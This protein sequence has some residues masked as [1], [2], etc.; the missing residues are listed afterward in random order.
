MAIEEITPQQARARQQLGAVLIDVREDDEHALGAPADALLRPRASL[1][2]DPAQSIP[3]LSVEVVLICGSGKRSMLAARALEN[4][5]Y[6]HVASIA[7][8]F[9]AWQAAGLPISSRHDA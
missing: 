8:G 3:G 6:L 1:E 2:R 4:Q 5:G 9:Q 7:G